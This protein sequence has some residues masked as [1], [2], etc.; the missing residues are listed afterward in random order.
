[1]SIPD[2]RI[3]SGIAIQTSPK[4]I[5]EAK[6]MRVTAAIRQEVNA[7]AKLSKSPNLLLVTASILSRATGWRN[8]KEISL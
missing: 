7:F 5:P 1:M 3:Q 8:L 6:D 2:F 4:G